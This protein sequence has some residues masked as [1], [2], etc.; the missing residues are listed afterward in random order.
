MHRTSPLNDELPPYPSQRIITFHF[1]PYLKIHI[2]IYIN[3]L[4][5][6]RNKY[7]KTSKMTTTYP[8]TS[9]ISTLLTL[10]ESQIIPLTRT[11]ISTGSKLFGAAILSR[12]SLTPI[13][14]A[15]NDE[16]TS[17]LLHGEINCI[18]TFFLSNPDPTTR[19]KTSDC[20][21]YATHEPCSLCLSGITWSGFN[22]FY[23]LFT[24]EDS[25]DLFSIPYDIDILTSVYQV[26]GKGETEESLSEKPLY[27]RE[28]KFFKAKSVGELVEMVEDE[29][30][31]ERL[32][33]EV[34]RVKGLYDELSDIYQKG[35]AE[36]RES[37]SIFQ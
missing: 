37:S 29:G 36:G 32:R 17:P 7:H 30:E 31:R 11:K 9:L 28:N 24:Y 27:N 3:H 15:T 22:E 2:I 19:P 8:P 16:R 26:R 4:S 10:T 33:G 21:F 1:G 25:R 34:R 13:T 5:R 20:I 35:K 23:Y 14:V 12:D 18:Q 6:T